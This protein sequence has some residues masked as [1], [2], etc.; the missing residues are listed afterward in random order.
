MH[1]DCHNSELEQRAETVTCD[2]SPDEKVT[3]VQYIDCE[4]MDFLSHEKID[5]L[6]EARALA[7]DILDQTHDDA[8]EEGLETGRKEGYEKRKREEAS[9]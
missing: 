6:H 2:L 5:E 8:L 1:P 7:E 3:L 9:V 4:G